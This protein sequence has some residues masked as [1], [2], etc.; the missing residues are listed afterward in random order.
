[1]A[2]ISS[3]SVFRTLNSLPCRL[4]QIYG[5]LEICY[6]TWVRV[7]PATFSCYYVIS[8]QTAPD[9]VID[10]QQ[11][12]PEMNLFSWQYIFMHTFLFV[13]RYL[14]Y[15]LIIP[16]LIS[17][18]F[19]ANLFW[20]EAHT[21]KEARAHRSGAT[22]P[23]WASGW[24]YL[25]SYFCFRL[26]EHPQRLPSSGQSVCEGVTG[27]LKGKT[28]QT[29]MILFGWASGKDRIKHS[30]EMWGSKLSRYRTPCA[31]CSCPMWPG[32]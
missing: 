5:F 6:K 29:L 16:N 19:L 18:W 23:L 14:R 32:N 4:K 28:V 20:P 24:V 31:V 15:D 17:L 10:K 3:L 8:N 30:A 7:N 13:P 21:E 22:A 1:M 26:S 2:F 9:Y 11:K 27:A 12:A 25:W